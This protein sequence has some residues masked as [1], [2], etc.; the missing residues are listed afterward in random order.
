MAKRRSP[1]RRRGRLQR[2]QVDIEGYDRYRDGIRQP[3]RSHRRGVH[4]RA[5][6][7]QL[8]DATMRRMGWRWTQDRF[9]PI[10]GGPEA[11]EF[12]A[13]NENRSPFA[14]NRFEKS[15]ALEFVRDLY[16]AGAIRVEV[17]FESILQKPE[18]IASEG[19]PY[20]DTL[21]VRAPG[22]SVGEHHEDGLVIPVLKI[23]GREFDADEVTKEGPDVYRLWW[24]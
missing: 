17:E 16:A 10:E 21:L 5:E 9:R 6:G 2:R 8:S 13:R 14:A 15:E 4:V 22:A 20:A 1:R 23:G 24:D 18:R 3:V 12:I 11:A 7:R 19:G